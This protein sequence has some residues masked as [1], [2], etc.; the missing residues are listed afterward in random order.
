MSV[1]IAPGSAF[2]GFRIAFR[3]ELARAKALAGTKP[4]TAVLYISTR[5]DRTAVAEILAANLAPL[6][7]TLKVKRF[8]DVF[9]AAD[10]PGADF[11]I[12]D[13]G[14]G[15]DW[16]D[17]SDLVD[18][19]FTADGYRPSWPEPLIAVPP[20][21]VGRI[22]HMRTLLGQPR[23][24]AYAQLVRDLERD[25]VPLAGYGTAVLPEFFSARMGCRIEQPILGT[26]DLAALCVKKS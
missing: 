2:A 19:A 6:G 9:T 17:P 20:A 10:K 4:R 7:I 26:V 23:A 24:H 22:K 15:L 8:D 12:V 11:D 5:P 3:P 16:P 21:Y 18:L 1:E 14:W 25:V 13:S